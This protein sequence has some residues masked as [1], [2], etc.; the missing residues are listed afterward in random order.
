MLAHGSKVT[1]WTENILRTVRVAVPEDGNPK[2]LNYIYTF[3]VYSF[4][5]IDLAFFIN[6]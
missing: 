3:T 6:K 2:S 4:L 1:Q 5:K